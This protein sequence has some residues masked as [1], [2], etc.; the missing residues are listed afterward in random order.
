MR[1]HVSYDGKLQKATLVKAA[2]CG[3]SFIAF[4]RWVNPKGNY[5]DAP[6]V[7]LYHL[8]GVGFYAV[9]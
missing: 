7:R 4:G 3:S 5:A 6:S 2:P 8:Q 1:T 9:E